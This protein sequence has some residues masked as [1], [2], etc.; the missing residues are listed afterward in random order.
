MRS[1][2]SITYRDIRWIKK[3]FLMLPWNTHRQLLLQGSPVQE[4]VILHANSWKTKLHL[5]H[6]HLNELF[7]YIKSG[8]RYMIKWRK[9]KWLMSLFAG[10]L[11]MRRLKTSWTNIKRTEVSWCLM[12]LWVILVKQWQ[13]VSQYILTIWIVL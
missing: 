8:N 2:C 4:R 3:K 10:C 13:I 5:H 11:M 6:P 9:I 1:R 7:L 12:I